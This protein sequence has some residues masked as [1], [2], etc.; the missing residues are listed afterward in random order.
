[1]RQCRGFQT[2]VV[3][4]GLLAESASSELGWCSVTRSPNIFER[5]RAAPGL[6]GVLAVAA[7][8]DAHLHLDALRH[9]K[10]GDGGK[11]SFKPH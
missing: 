8:I 5:H 11:T 3:S 1:M 9:N 2:Y 4:S 10:P 7:R 6:L